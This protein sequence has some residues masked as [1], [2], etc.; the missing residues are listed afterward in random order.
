[1]GRGCRREAPRTNF[2]KTKQSTTARLKHG[3]SSFKK[4][5]SLLLE[6]FDDGEISEDEFFLLYD[7]NKSK[8]P[9][10][11]YEHYERFDLEEC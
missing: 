4:T 6:S 11:P 2:K 5:R 10:F 7:E 1:M 3:R 9:A 8:N